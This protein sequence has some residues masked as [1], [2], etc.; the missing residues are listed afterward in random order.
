MAAGQIALVAAVQGCGPL[1]AFGE[2]A[3]SAARFAML[4]LT[5]V[6]FL[7]FP[8]HERRQPLLLVAAAALLWLGL[9][10]LLLAEPAVAVAGT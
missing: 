9:H 4:F 7:H 6:A 3:R 1:A 8:L 10:S 2:A 5:G